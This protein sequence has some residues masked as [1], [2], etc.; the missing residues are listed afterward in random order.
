MVLQLLSSHSVKLMLSS[1]TSPSPCTITRTTSHRCVTLR[2]ASTRLRPPHH[3][4]GS[5]TPSERPQSATAAVPSLDT[6]HQPTDRLTALRSSPHGNPALS[7][8]GE[9]TA[10]YDAVTPGFISELQVTLGLKYVE[11]AGI[12]EIKPYVFLSP[13]TSLPIDC[14]PGN[15]CVG[16]FRSPRFSPPMFGQAT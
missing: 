9:N 1:P 16:T 7:G 8:R 14:I 10:Q 3:S 13:S 12:L 15:Y 6:A 2:P 5:S 4:C 11:V